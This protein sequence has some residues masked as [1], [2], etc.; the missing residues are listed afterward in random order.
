MTMPQILTPA[1]GSRVVKDES[2]TILFGQPPEVLK[3]L[4]R[5][6]ISRFDTLVL[7][8]IKEK[9]GSLLNNLEFPFYFFL[10]VAKGFAEK[11]KINLVGDAE[12]IS[13]AI[14]RAS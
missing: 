8:D 7:T 1:P 5:E 14:S 4:L 6:N 12:S 10:F 2:E 9:N 13:Q 3:G 11:R